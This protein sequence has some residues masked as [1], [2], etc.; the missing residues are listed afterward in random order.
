[1]YIYRHRRLDTFEIFYVGI[2]SDVRYKRAYNKINRSFWWKNITNKHKYQVE[3]VQEGLS[4]GDA[5]ELEIFLISLYGRKDLNKGSL[6]NMS[7]GGESAYGAIRSEETKD[8]YKKSKEGNKNP[9]FG[10][11]GN[12]SPRFGKKLTQKSK[13]EIKRSLG[14]Q[15]KGGNNANAKLVLNLDNGIFYDYVGEAAEAY[16]IKRTTLTG[17]LNG[18][19][20]NKTR[21]IYC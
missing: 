7:N 13:N 6:V 9:M 16:G 20:K 18:T 21:L 12:L 10:K 4:L 19:N 17:Q 2:G 1:M 14:L 11:R 15:T 5:K 3:I 8:K